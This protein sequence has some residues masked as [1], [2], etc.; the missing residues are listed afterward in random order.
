MGIHKTQSWHPGDFELCNADKSLLWCSFWR[1][2]TYTSV[3][4]LLGST[5]KDEKEKQT[6]HFAPPPPL[7]PP[8]FF[9]SFL[10]HF[11]LFCRLTEKW[12]TGNTRNRLYYIWEPKGESGAKRMDKE[13]IRAPTQDFL[14][15]GLSIELCKS[16]C[17]MLI[18][19]SGI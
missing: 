2:M 5:R 12:L 13:V 14:A 4:A 6:L 17:E 18:V 1:L 11:R 16:E 10:C 15:I 9:F 8:K 19:L 3:K 7:L